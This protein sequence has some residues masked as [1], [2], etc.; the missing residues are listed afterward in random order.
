[1]ANILPDFKNYVKY[2]YVFVI[3]NL[4]WE[5][6]IGKA[7]TKIMTDR[8]TDKRKAEKYY[9][10]YESCSEEF[11]KQKIHSLVIHHQNQSTA[12]KRS[13]NSINGNIQYL[14]KGSY[15]AVVTAIG[16]MTTQAMIRECKH[17]F[18]KNC[19]ILYGDTDSIMICFLLED[20]LLLYG[21][22]SRV[23]CMLDPKK[24]I[25]NGELIEKAREFAN[26]FLND[27]NL[28][29]DRTIVRVKMQEWLLN[30]Q[31]IPYLNTKLPLFPFMKIGKTKET[32]FP[33]L[34]PSAKMYC[35]LNP[36]D[37]YSFFT[38]GMS[39][40]NKNAP[41]LKKDILTKWMAI[42]KK[43]NSDS[44]YLPNMLNDMYHY[45]G[46]DVLNSIIVDENF[47][48]SKVAFKLSINKS[49]ITSQSKKHQLLLRLRA[50]G[51]ESAFESEKVKVVPVMPMGIDQHWSLAT[52]LQ[53]KENNLK[54]NTEKIL[55]D[56]ISELLTI[57]SSMVECS[58]AIIDLFNCLITKQYLSNINS[59]MFKK[60]II[61]KPTNI[62]SRDFKLSEGYKLQEISTSKVSFQQ[63]LKG[64]QKVE[65][66]FMFNWMQLSEHTVQDIFLKQS[67][68]KVKKSFNE[69]ANI[70]MGSLKQSTLD[71][72]LKNCDSNISVKKKES[73]KRPSTNN[74]NLITK[75]FRKDDK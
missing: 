4:K 24:L 22:S 26:K 61:E 37:N 5:S 72:F 17:L 43:Y 34:I 60:L 39:L 44:Y 23:A 42:M 64:K 57:F 33:F 11:E 75:F 8:F 68:E 28:E 2:H 30:F 47:L 29:F 58:P 51:N 14:M 74:I 65:S 10:Q 62:S 16:R 46:K 36:I 69:K 21:D 15:R 12:K 45:L 70:K 25:L 49:K 3:H 1:M 53:I 50:E 55:L 40:K 32:F 48:Y 19:L 7:L 18:E 73:T 20:V 54:L 56:N 59:L 38:K 31:I 52:V 13:L 67:V 63:V 6:S 41:G 35:G 71:G 27:K 66:N 9:E